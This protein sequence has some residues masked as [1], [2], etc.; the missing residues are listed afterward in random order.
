MK[1]P[2]RAP[3]EPLLSRSF[4]GLL[5]WQGLL[6]TAVTLAAF[7]LGLGW[8]GWEG[9]GLRRAET[10]AFMTLALAQVFHAFN[11]RSQRRSAFDDRLFT[12]GWLWAAVLA[13]VLLQLA[14]VYWP[15]LQAVLLTVPLT[16][17]DWALVLALALAPVGV[18]ELV[19]LSRRLV[20]RPDARSP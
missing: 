1:R 12:N 7:R 3:N 20:V 11:A 19:K 13:C 2:P 15:F 9:E 17:A 8:Y 4:V 10:L 18:V 14:A 6:L 5:A 16:A